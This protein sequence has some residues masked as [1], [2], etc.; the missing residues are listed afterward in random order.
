MLG[1]TKVYFGIKSGI[2]WSWSHFLLHGK[3]VFKDILVVR[4]SKY[5][6]TSPLLWSFL[7]ESI[8]TKMHT[9]LITAK[10]PGN[11][12]L[13]KLCKLVMLT[14]E[15]IPYLL[16]SIY[17]ETKLLQCW[18][19]QTIRTNKPIRLLK[20]LTFSLNKKQLTAVHILDVFCK[21]T[22][23]TTVSI[24]NTVDWCSD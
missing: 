6:C 22:P 14:V 10:T 21:R 15:K 8:N 13:Q 11:I 18:H 20:K 1:I 16:F 7:Y 19:L 3:S 5:L 23:V 17:D 24:F 4:C 2:K 9:Y 12:K